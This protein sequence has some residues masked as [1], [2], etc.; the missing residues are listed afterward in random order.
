MTV[1]RC[2]CDLSDML[3]PAVSNCSDGLVRLQATFWT[4]LELFLD[5]PEGSRHAS[6]IVFRDNT[7]LAA[8]IITT[9]V[10]FR[11]HQIDDTPGQIEALAA[12]RAVVS[13]IPPP[14]GTH[15]FAYGRTFPSIESYAA[16]GLEA[17]VN[18]S[19]GLAMVVVIVFALLASPVVALATCACI[20]SAAVETV[21]LLNFA[22]FSIDSVTVVFLVVSLGLAVDYSVHVAHAFLQAETVETTSRLEET[23][24]VRIT[25]VM[26]GGMSQ[27][28]VIV[29]TLYSVSCV[30]C[31]HRVNRC[32]HTEQYAPLQGGGAAACGA[33][34]TLLA[35]LF[36]ASA[37]SYVIVTLFHTLLLI[38][39]CGTFQGLVVLPVLLGM[40]PR[41]TRQQPSRGNGSVEDGAGDD[42]ATQRGCGAEGGSTSNGAEMRKHGDAQG[43]VT[44]QGTS[45]CCWAT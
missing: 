11:W 26:T 1:S 2:A 7:V 17:L 39:L 14:Y 23:M 33:L 15:A 40:L 6:N 32:K 25:H 13:D 5:S 18:I 22:G 36:L 42:A 38:V 21:G 34:S 31:T 8:G 45:V 24:M 35:T 43:G 29:Y 4:D 44:L 28:P 27:C 12:T 41:A 10:Q 37:R 9:R 19:S 20:L 30:H 16:I 3:Y